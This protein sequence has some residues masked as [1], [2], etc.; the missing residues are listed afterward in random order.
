MYVPELDDVADML[1]GRLRR[2]QPYISEAGDDDG[3]QQD[4]F[5]NTLFRGMDRSGRGEESEQP[6]GRERYRRT[7]S[8]ISPLW[9]AAPGL[10]FSSPPV[11]NRSS[12]LFT[13]TD[14][15]ADEGSSN[16]VLP[17]DSELTKIGP[18]SMAEAE[19]ALHDSSI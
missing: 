12:G 2:A 11:S 18:G 3:L 5:E 7:A 1:R 9:E 8:S 4:A 13:Y 16:L 19:V 6:R 15:E 14:K 10:S 17:T